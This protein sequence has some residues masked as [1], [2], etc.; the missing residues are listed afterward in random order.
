[1]SLLNYFWREIAAAIAAVMK[2]AIA[3][4]T[5]A[6]IAAVMKAA[7]A[8]ATAAAIAAAIAVTDD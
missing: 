4:A 5:A 7:I 3:A 1:M 2:A 8:A 6:A